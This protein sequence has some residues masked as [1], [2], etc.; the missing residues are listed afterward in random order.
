MSGDWAQL[1]CQAWNETPDLT[2]GLLKWMEN[3][4]DRGFKIIQLYR[5]DCAES[6][7]SRSSG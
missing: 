3:D 1:T 7:A 6:R 4:R 5:T 2:E